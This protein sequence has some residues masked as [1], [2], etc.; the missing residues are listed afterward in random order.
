M[1]S[2]I[3]SGLANHLWQ[4]TA[5]AIVA[6]GLTL[7]L[8]KNQARTRHWIW[9]IASLKFLIPFSVLIQFGSYFPLRSAPSIAELP[10]SFVVA[11]Q[12]VRPFA[13][14]NGAATPRPASRSSNGTTALQGLLILVWFGGAA[15]ILFRTRVQWRR[16][17]RMI[18]SAMPIERGRELDLLRGIEESSGTRAPIPLRCTEEAS[19]PSVFG[20]FRPI[21]LMPAGLMA[22]LSDDE[23]QAVFMHE[24]AHAMRR[25]N[26]FASLHMIVE[27]FFW[28]H[29]LVWWVG[30]R[31]VDERERACDEA[32]L[33]M[34]GK[35]AAYAES[36]IKV[37]EACLESPL[38]CAAGVTGSNLSKRIEAI[39]TEPFSRKLSHGRKLLLVVTGIAALAAPIFMGAWSAPSSAQ[40]STAPRPKFEVASIKRNVGGTGASFGPAPGGRLVADNNPAMN[41]ITNAYGVPRYLV[42]GAPDWVTADRYNIEA[43]AEGSPTEMQMMPMLQSLLE[44][45][46]S[47]KTHRETREMPVFILTAPKG[48]KL[49]PSKVDC[50]RYDPNAPAQARR[51]DDKPTCNNL[52]SG[53]EPVRWSAQNIDMTGVTGALSN[54]LRR[55]VI[56]RTGFTG[57]FDINLEFTRDV[58]TDDN[59]PPSLI[60]VLQD[61]L[62]LKL[63][64]GKAPV[65]VFVIDHIERPTEN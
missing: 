35:S 37:C 15:A 16:A 38:T 4:S 6:A 41:F 3:L 28:F 30:K 26:L 12:I 25:D 57:R 19:E 20:V 2:M 58:T 21:L 46:F 61:E 34:G 56:D 64:S 9:L 11:D 17:A 42:V 40:S 36:I 43:K 39:L 51:A 10:A 45:R 59:A 33:H 55:R 63:E 23:L 7:V 14:R 49:P 44:E 29:P 18:L 47:L 13:A 32:V 62:G 52:L 53:R 5:F 48:A 54:V 27:M 24:L 60:T 65:E 8:R 1:I 50:V 22:R 31:L